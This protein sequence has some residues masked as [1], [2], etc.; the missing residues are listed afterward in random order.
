MVL[1]GELLRRDS[2]ELT[3]ESW[4][5]IRIRSCSSSVRTDGIIDMLGIVP[6]GHSQPDLILGLAGIG[7]FY[8][9]LYDPKIPLVLF[10]EPE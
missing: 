6:T 9:G 1:G 7:H 2:A 3:A 5:V 10:V 4:E 8:L